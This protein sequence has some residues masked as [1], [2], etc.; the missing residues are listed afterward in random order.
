M[1]GRQSLPLLWLQASWL[2]L[3]LAARPRL[4]AVLQRDLPPAVLVGMRN[5]V[6]ALTWY[7]INY[8][9][10]TL[11]TVFKMLDIDRRKYLWI[12]IERKTSEED[13]LCF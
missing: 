5:P 11:M 4:V 3:L 1:L 9:V 8:F 2:L 6:A 7:V 13:P 10:I 12:H